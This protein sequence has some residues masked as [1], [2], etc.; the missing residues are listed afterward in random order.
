M[1]ESRDLAS[2]VELRMRKVARLFSIVLVG[3]AGLLCASARADNVVYNVTLNTAPLENPSTGTVYLDFAM[4]TG[5]AQNAVT[6]SNFNF[7]NGGAATGS[8]I[9][10]AGDESG[11]LYSSVSLDTYN[12]ANPDNELYQTFT[13]GDTLS[14]TVTSTNVEAPA[15]TTP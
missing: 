1:N 3:W 4:Y 12:P 13:P 11:S 5:N 8:A 2:G 10:F 9:P 7:G 14:F 6:I 15:N